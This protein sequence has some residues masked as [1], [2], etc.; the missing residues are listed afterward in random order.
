ELE[1]EGS[2]E[3]PWVEDWCRTHGIPCE[4]PMILR[5]QLEP[6]GRSRAFV[7]DTPVLLDQLRGLGEGLVHVHSQHH[8]LLL[9][10]PAFQLGLLDHF[11]GQ[12][13]A[14]KHYAARYQAWRKAADELGRLRAEEAKA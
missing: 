2:A 12:A 3:M 7:N 4:S 6:G 10:S 11:S 9:N 13:P 14:V 8:T 5:R 1:L